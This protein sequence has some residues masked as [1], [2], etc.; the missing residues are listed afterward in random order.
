MSHLSVGGEGVPKS[1]AL[2]LTSLGHF[3]ND[4]TLFLF[5]LLVDIVL[6]VKLFA[7]VFAA[8]FLTVFYIMG[9]AFSLV[10]GRAAD[11]GFSLGKLI[12]LGLFLYPLGLLG[13]YFIIQYHVNSFPIVLV[14]TLLMGTA[15]SFYHPL[16]ASVL[17]G[18]YGSGSTGTALGINGAIGSVG[19]ALYPSLLFVVAAAL[20]LAR[21]F[22]FFAALAAVAAVVIAAGLRNCCKQAETRG[23]RAKALRSSVATPLILLTILVFARSVATQGI[24]SWIPVYLSNV[25]SLGLSDSLGYTL[26][27]MFAGGIVGQP[28]FGYLTRKFDKRVLLSLTSFGTAVTILGYIN[29]TGMEALVMLGVFG[30]FTFSGFPLLFSIIQDYVQGTS[31]TVN[32]LVWGLGSQGGMAAGPA[33]V[34]LLALNDYSALTTSFYLMIALIFVVGTAFLFM[35]KSSTKKKMALF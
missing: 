6:S 22:L 32:S 35:P 7:P 5:P 15:S 2:L 28:V 26:S 24:I 17:Q 23:T 18:S 19:R 30:F 8:V 14:S 25:K 31:S 9:S 12:G 4:G 13:F 21:S 10:V 33:V 29:T 16:G 27:L 3:I 1:R 34:G 20:T 11:R